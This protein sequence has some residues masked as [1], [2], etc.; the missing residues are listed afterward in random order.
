[1]KLFIALLIFLITLPQNNSEKIMWS[2]SYKLSWND[3]RGK[4]LRSASFV[5]TTNSG[6]S[7]Q[8]SYSIK[9]NKVS[10]DYS[11]S[12]FFEPNN[13]WYIPEK[14]NDYILKHEQ[15]HFDISELHARMLKK[16]LEG[17]QF[18][19][20]VQSEIEK[21]YREVEQKRRAMQTKFDTE[22]DHSRN[23]KQELY[24][25]EYIAKQLAE[26]EHWK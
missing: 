17:K 12:S 23:D 21:I 14:V 8:Y 18:S 20:S 6:I 15:L 10:V 11:V 19:K 16:N 24:W 22:T 9:N 25:R 13:S 2:E 26:Y 1:M 7:F 4:P 5:A 3:F